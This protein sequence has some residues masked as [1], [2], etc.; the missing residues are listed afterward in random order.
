MKNILVSEV[1][2]LSES[3]SLSL[4]ETTPLEEVITQFAHQPVVRAIFLVDSNERFAG[5]IRRLDLLKW[6]HL[7]LYGRTGGQKAST[8]EILRLTFAQKARDLARGDSTSMGIR[9][10]ETLQNAMNKMIQYGEGILPVLDDDGKILG[11]LR[12][13]DILLKLIELS[14]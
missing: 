12:V 5:M 1:Y 10:S 4:P 6:L 8:G 9:P 14:D 7:Q 11:D 13:T 3:A 2:T